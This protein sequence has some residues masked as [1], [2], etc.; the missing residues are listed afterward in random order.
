MSY[1]LV[2]FN[3]DIAP[4]NT[5][6]FARWYE[7]QSEE[8]HDPSELECE[9]LQSFFSEIHA[10]YPA[11]NGPYASEAID[12]PKL[13]DYA[14]GP[15]SIYMC[16]A[17]SQADEAREAVTNLAAQCAVGF[18]DIS[19][20]QGFTWWPPKP[21]QYGVFYC[22]YGSKEEVSNNLPLSLE[23]SEV[24]SRLL[25]KLS[26]D[27]DFLGIVDSN[28]VTVQFM[29]HKAE[30]RVWM[31][32]PVPQ[33]RGSYGAYLPPEELRSIIEGLSG[34]FHLRHFPMLKFQ[35]WD[36]PAQPAKKPWWKFW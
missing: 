35:S 3:Q 4:S 18:Y 2:V 6:A 33:E 17:W 31:E 32:I 21:G 27:S 1:D 34:Q 19:D 29:L 26:S 5:S 30:N 11:M 20:S 23:P 16:F 12:N 28:G 22:F 7:E 14:F 36:S 24:V 13:T 9:A 25:P 10:E 15:H 8:S